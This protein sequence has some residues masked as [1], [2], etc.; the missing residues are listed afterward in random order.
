MLLF[1]LLAI[2]IREIIQGIINLI[3]EIFKQIVQEIIEELVDN[4][5]YFDE[6]FSIDAF[7]R[8]SSTLF[9][10]S[11]VE[12]FINDNPEAT[13][14][15]II[16]FAQSQGAAIAAMITKTWVTEPGGRANN[17][18]PDC[19]SLDGQVVM[20]D[21]T[22]SSVKAGSLEAPPAHPNCRCRIQLDF[23]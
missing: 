21:Q 17:V 18:C 15:D 22:F 16:E 12:D 1:Q 5:D 20:V 13:E 8:R 10:E 6:F 11:D 9:T 4:E 23:Q 19:S 14:D 2:I 7:W 3:E